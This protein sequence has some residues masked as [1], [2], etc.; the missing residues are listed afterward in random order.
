MEDPGY[1]AA[2]RD[3]ITR[4]VTKYDSIDD[5]EADLV[6]M[7]EEVRRLRR[8]QS[9]DTDNESLCA[10]SVIHGRTPF[11]ELQENIDSPAQRL[12]RAHE[13]QQIK[14]VRSR[15]QIRG[16]QTSPSIVHEFPALASLTNSTKD[17][18]RRR[19][20][21]ASIEKPRRPSYAQILAHKNAEHQISMD[22]ASFVKSKA[23]RDDHLRLEKD[24]RLNTEDDSDGETSVRHGNIDATRN[25]LHDRQSELLQRQVDRQEVF[26][27]QVS[28]RGGPDFSTEKRLEKRRQRRELPVNWDSVRQTRRGHSKSPLVEAMWT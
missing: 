27:T 28:T 22:Q 8:Q 14:G 3:H 15:P 25:E 26:P 18:A 12:L 16:A 21:E 9:S 24:N 11:L 6:K 2:S 10:D 20:E 5:L 23:G 1:F 4:P 13:Q 19:T 7:T 17:Q